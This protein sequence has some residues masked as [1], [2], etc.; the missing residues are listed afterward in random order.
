M[1]N[2]HVSILAVRSQNILPNTVK[3]LF[4]FTST[5]FARKWYIDEVAEI[6]IADSWRLQ[7]TFHRACMWLDLISTCASH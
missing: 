3:Y 4:S 7:R 6:M 2:D 1:A 5:Y